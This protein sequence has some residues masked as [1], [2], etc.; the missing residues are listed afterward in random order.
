MLIA[1][2]SRHAKEVLDLVEKNNQKEVFFFDDYSSTIQSFFSDFTVFRDL[3]SLKSHFNMNDKQFVLGIGNPISR[4]KVEKK[5]IDIGGILSSVLSPNADIGRREVYIGQGVNIMSF[6]YI[7]NSVQIGKS[8]LINCHSSIHH[9]ARVG[10]YSEVSPHAC[11]LGGAEIGAFTSVGSHAVI[12]PNVKVGVN[13]QIGA[14][15]VVRMDI[16]DN[17]V[18][19]GVPGKIIRTI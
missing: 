8:A 4:F 7:G 3:E 19:Y 6:V 2:A 12:F 11:L 15:S 17:S 18:V 10:E 5:I 1:G 14:G 16:P 9:D 13:C